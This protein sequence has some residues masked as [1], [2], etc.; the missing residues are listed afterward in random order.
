MHQEMTPMDPH[1]FVERTGKEIVKLLKK[2]D[3]L[4]TV[5]FNNFIDLKEGLAF[6]YGFMMGAVLSAITAVVFVLMLR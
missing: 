1:V 3:P 4:W 6:R 2:Q 5:K